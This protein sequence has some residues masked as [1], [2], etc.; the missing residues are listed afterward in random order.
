VVHGRYALI[1]D[2][3]TGALDAGAPFVRAGLRVSLPFSGSPGDVREADV[4]LLNTASREGT[5]E[6]AGASA[7]RAALALRDAGIDR[8]YKKIDS[9]LRGHPGAELAA[10]LDVYGGR[11]AV[12][13]AFPAQG[14]I[15]RDGVQYVAGQPA[16]PFG[17]DVRAAL[18][19]AATRCDVFDA[20]TD[21]DLSAIA[22][23]AAGGDYRVWCGTAG[24][25][26]SVPAALG[27]APAGAGPIV[28]PPATQVL[29]VAGSLHPATSAQ[30]KALAAAGWKHIAVDIEAAGPPGDLVAR[31]ADALAGDGH[32]VV[33]F[34][35]EH[36]SAA[37]MRRLVAPAGTAARLL[38]PLAAAVSEVIPATITHRRLG[39]VLTGGETGLWVA[40]ALGARAIDVT[41][42]S[43]PGVPLGVLRLPGADVPVATKSGGFGGAAA[44]M[45]AA[46]SLTLTGA[47][48][49][50]KPRR[51]A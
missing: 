45:E 27:L 20:S 33:S 13:P 50:V 6:A 36:L 43:Q 30:V 15:T 40:R 8:V 31:L 2:D 12:A 35:S 9:V 26:T 14:R 25:A 24:L 16:P 22:R 17:G 38:G 47:H 21:D 46:D 3:L 5:A 18:G 49:P 37:E 34:R 41:G 1:A 39:L 23:L 19:P 29:V 42:E 32:V 11:A 4:V 51:E 48:T 10:V 28:R 7:G 44:L